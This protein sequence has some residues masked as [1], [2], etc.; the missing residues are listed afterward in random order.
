MKYTITTVG[1]NNKVYK[2]VVVTGGDASTEK[3]LTLVSGGMTL[4]LKDDEDVFAPIKSTSASITVRTVEDLT[5]V[6]SVDAFHSAVCITEDDV[7]IFRGYVAPLQLSQPWAARATEVEI[8]CVDAINIL[9]YVDFAEFGKPLPSFVEYLKEACHIVSIDNTLRLRI[10]E[11]YDVSLSKMAVSVGNW[12]DEDNEPCKWSDVLKEL[13]KFANM[14]LMMYGDDVI[15]CDSRW[16]GKTARVD[17]G[18]QVSTPLQRLDELSFEGNSIT[19][20]LTEVYNR[21]KVSVSLYSD[22]AAMPELFDKETTKPVGGYGDT[23]LTYN[24]DKDTLKKEYYTF[25]KQ[26]GVSCYG[27]NLPGLSWVSTEDDNDVDKVCGKVGAWLVK[28][29][30][31]KWPKSY[32]DE[33]SVNSRILVNDDT[34]RAM[35]LINK[36]NSMV[37]D[38]DDTKH[39]QALVYA[40]K[41]VCEIADEN[42]R[43]YAGDYALV[44][45]GKV[46][47]SPELTPKQAASLPTSLTQT[48]AYNDMLKR[49]RTR[50]YGGDMGMGARTQASYI[51]MM[52][53]IGDK[54][55][56]NDNI[57]NEEG[58]MQGEW[59]TEPSTFKAYMAL[60]DNVRYHVDI[61]GEKEVRKAG[62]DVVLY[63]IDK[64]EWLNNKSFI[65]RNN[66]SWTSG[67]DGKGLAIP[68]KASDLIA[69]KLTLTIFMPA[70]PYK[71]VVQWIMLED[72]K[73]NL[74]RVGENGVAAA[75]ADDDDD[76]VEYSN[77]ADGSSVR[78]SEDIDLKVATDVGRKYS[79]G[80]VVQLGD[81]YSYIGKLKSA[82]TGTGGQVAEEHLIESRVNQYNKPNEVLSGTLR[83]CVVDWSRGMASTALGKKYI[84]TGASID[85]D[86]SKSDVKLIEIR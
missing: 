66:I 73:L 82:I 43:V 9:Q 15:V 50:Y 20:S 52:L 54:Y 55:W 56:K 37:N 29:T 7:V 72:L 18:A 69:G 27:T 32:G 44:L 25:Y 12:F 62:Q 13:M 42:Y 47:Y 6:Y 59:T 34:E 84:V 4:T 2:A 61:Y 41:E 75:I 83:N 76:D 5:D 38:Y 40:D 3:E 49:A 30:S 21:V 28:G 39:R 80:A 31:I 58:S 71:G 74:V 17:N 19:R 65:I 86:R 63:G 8:E 14:S 36:Y 1:K 57:Y 85:L 77:V 24:Y 68:I 10:T 64:G 81:G 67:I 60:D 23:S 53:K 70:S 11:S 79:R 45:S 51:T 33:A 35:L 26:K 16:L 46:T 48:N 78:D 22:D